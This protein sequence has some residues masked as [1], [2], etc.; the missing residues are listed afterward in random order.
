MDLIPVST[1]FGVPKATRAVG[2]ANGRNRVAIIVPCHRVIAADGSLWGYGGGLERN[3]R[4]LE[5]EGALKKT[6]PLYAA[7]RN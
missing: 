1:Q 2:L 6:T 4:L 7:L 3:R 5:H